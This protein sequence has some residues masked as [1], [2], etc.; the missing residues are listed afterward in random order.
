MDDSLPPDVLAAL[1]V[2]LGDGDDPV[3]AALRRQV[4]HLRTAGRCDCGCGTT[5]FSI[6]TAAVPA[7]APTGSGTGS[8]ASRIFQAEDGTLLGDLV[9]FAQGG[10]LSWLEVCDLTDVHSELKVTLDLALRCFARPAPPSR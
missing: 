6:D 4:P 10:H 1:D 9:L 7:A 8:V 2:L 5:D 3:H